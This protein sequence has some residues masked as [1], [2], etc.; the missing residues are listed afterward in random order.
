[1]IRPSRA[2][3]GGPFDP[4]TSHRPSSQQTQC[5]PLPVR[6]GPARLGPGAYGRIRSAPRADSRTPHPLAT[7]AHGPTLPGEGRAEGL[8]GEETLRVSMSRISG[9]FGQAQLL[10][11][12]SSHSKLILL[13]LIQRHK[14][15]KT[16]ST[17][18]KRTHHDQETN[19]RTGTRHS[20]RGS[21]CTD[22]GGGRT[23]LVLQLPRWPLPQVHPKHREPRM[24]DLHSA[25]HLWIP[26]LPCVESLHP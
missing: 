12:N 11:Y 13:S 21:C 18:L 26:L 22:P 6:E 25:Q 20:G 4:P 9:I 8:E 2:P 1:M 7:F 23:T 17:D 5:I 3:P 10:N 16:Q 15:L 24:E 14:T 19:P